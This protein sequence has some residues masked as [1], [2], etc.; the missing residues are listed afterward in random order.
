MVNALIKSLVGAVIGVP[1]VVTLCIAPPAVT[2]AISIVDAVL[3]VLTV[4][5]PSY[6]VAD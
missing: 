3:T 1:A 6:S 2:V 5:T 4:N